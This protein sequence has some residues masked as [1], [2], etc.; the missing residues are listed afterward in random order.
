MA[1][2]HMPSIFYA[3]SAGVALLQVL[4]IS[5]V[6]SLL[7]IR[8]TVTARDQLDI[9]GQFDKR[10]TAQL[11][12]YSAFNEVIF[13]QLSESIEDRRKTSGRASIA[14]LKRLQ[15][16]HHGEP[17]AWGNGVTVT[18]QDLNGLLPQLFP[19][20]FL[21][22]ELLRRRSFDDTEIA[23]YLGIWQDLHDADKQ[24]WA[25]GEIEPDA[26]PSGGTYPDGFAQNS[27]VL[28]W[29]FADRPAVLADLLQFSDINAD[30]DTNFLNVP[31]A[32]LESLFTPSVSTGIG[33]LRKQP[34][35]TM[36]RVL[37]LLPQSMRRDNLTISE[38]GKLV[39][40]VEVNMD[41][42]HWRQRRTLRLVASSKPPFEVILNN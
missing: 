39:V 31:N 19:A 42:A 30:F 21:W 41:G 37:Q 6:I 12:A 22:P 32:L 27:K 18:I 17:V 36:N 9:A 4:L 25:A 2:K 1:V 20:H 7:A 5:S 35:V 29:V 14:A 3:R 23:A 11:A 16:N 34:Q 15:L 10:I 8:F 28:E 38:S 13:L 33:D 40:K 24:S 26:L